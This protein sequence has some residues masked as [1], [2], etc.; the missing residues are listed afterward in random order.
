MDWIRPV[1]GEPAIQLRLLRLRNRKRLEMSRDAIPNLLH[2]LNPD[3]I[4][5]RANLA[6]EGTQVGIDPAYL[7]SLSAD[8]VPALLD[9]RR[10]LPNEYRLVVDAAVRARLESAKQGDWRSWNWSRAAVSGMVT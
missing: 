5:A 10:T 4:I 8:S 6:R 3:A 2:E 9:A 1:V 7:A